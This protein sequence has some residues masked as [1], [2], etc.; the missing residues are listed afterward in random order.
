MEFDSIREKFFGCQM[1][2][3]RAHHSAVGV[4]AVFLDHNDIK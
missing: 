2:A 3:C 4:L 1:R